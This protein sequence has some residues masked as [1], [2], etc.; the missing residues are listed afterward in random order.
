[1]MCT[2]SVCFCLL[3]SVLLCGQTNTP[4]AGAVQRKVTI[5]PGRASPPP[6]L[7]PQPGDAI[8]VDEATRELV[9]E[10]VAPSG[11]AMQARVA[12]P[13]R[14]DPVIGTDTEWLPSGLIRYTYTVTNGPRAQQNIHLFAVGMER[15]DLVQNPEAPP[16]WRCGGPS[17][18]D[19]ERGFPPRYNW[20]SRDRLPDLAP[21]VKSGPFRFEAASLPGLELAYVTGVMRAGEGAVHPDKWGISPWLRDQLEKAHSLIQQ[22][23]QRPV[24]SPKI[25]VPPAGATGQFAAAIADEMLAAS[26]LPEFQDQSQALEKLADQVRGGQVAAAP[27]HA[28]VQKMGTS[29]EQRSFFKAMAFNLEYLGRMR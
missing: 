6:P 23:V 5:V 3:G 2:K 16:S 14:V 1:M 24:V 4:E 7:E 21:G 11:E 18:G 8:R 28:D 20:W 15:P 9:L 13:A 17:R 26:R 27:L 10:W 25:P 22:T 12:R 29:P 19:L